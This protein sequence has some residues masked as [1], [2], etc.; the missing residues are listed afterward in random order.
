M[1][2]SEDRQR[3]DKERNRIVVA[4]KWLADRTRRLANGKNW[5]MDLLY[6]KGVRE[7][8]LHEREAEPRNLKKTMRNSSAM[9]H[10]PSMRRRWR[11]KNA[12]FGQRKEKGITEQRSGGNEKDESLKKVGELERRCKETETRRDKVVKQLD[13]MRE[14]FGDQG[15]DEPGL[16]VPRP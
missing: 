2:T 8:T 14:R 12:S 15:C 5:V 3:A 13:E 11:A 6:D 4:E 10:G 9:T 16:R 7:G 1:R